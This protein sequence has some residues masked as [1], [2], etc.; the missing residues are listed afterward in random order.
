MGQAW[1]NERRVMCSRETEMK[2]AGLFDGASW[3]SKEFVHDGV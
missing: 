3:S 1:G 2:C